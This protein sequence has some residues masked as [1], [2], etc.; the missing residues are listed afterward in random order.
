MKILI[1]GRGIKKTGIGRYIENTLREMLLLDKKNHYEMLIN[2]GDKKSINLSAKNLELVET[3]IPWFSL[4]EQTNLL[5]LINDRKPDLVHFTNFNFPVA[6]KGKFVITIHDLTLLHFRNLRSSITK[7]AYYMIKEGVM[8]HVVLK[9]GIAK[10]SSILVPT[11]YVRD[12]V[13]KTFGVKKNKINVTYEAVDKDFSKPKINLNKFNI[14]KPFVLYVGNAYPHKNLERMIIAFGKL[15]TEYVLDYQLVIAG[16]KDS[17]HKNLEQAVKEAGLEDRVVFTGYINDQELAGLYNKSKLY[18]FPSL[19]E[20]FG[21]P[22]LEAMAHGLPVVSSNATCLPEVLG[23]AAVYFNPKDINDMTKAMLSVLTEEK[24]S[25]DLI[26]KGKR[27][28]SKYSWKI[29]AKETLDV[30]NRAVNK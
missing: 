13:A 25:N 15:I 9:R 4:S 12:D 10:A 28:V 8:R 17:F 22:P 19:S 20:G 2:P 23:D 5:K 26:K 29:T 11:N 1:D 24:L 27:Q 14:D 7:K 3:E 21:L 18:I 30:Y 6:Y 16:R